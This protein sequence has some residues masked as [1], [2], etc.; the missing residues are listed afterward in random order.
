MFAASL[1]G[2]VSYWDTGE[3]QVVP[4]I[5]GIA[6]PTGFPV[7]TIGAGIFAHVVAIGPV[8][9]RIALFSAIAMS[10]ASWAVFRILREL[11]AE[12]W[13]A[14]GAACVFAFGQIVWTRGT[15]AEVHALAVCLAALTLYFT[16]RWYVRGEPRSFM[17]GALC[18]GLGVATH[19]VVALFAPALLVVV[20]TRIRQLKLRVFAAGLAVLICGLACYAYL[21]VRSAMITQARLDP[22][23]QLGDAP[24]KAFWDMNHPASWDGFKHEVS[25]SEYGSTGFLAAMVN[26]RT[27]HDGAPP[28]LEQLWRE[29]TPFGILLA[30]GGIVALARRDAALAIALLLA[31][32]IPAIFAF[33]Y[34]IEADIA[35]YYL[36]P[37]LVVAI[38]AGYGASA[39][40]RAMP[41]MRTACIVVVAGLA[42][43]LLLIN[44]DTFNQ[45]HS[46]GASGLIGTV[47]AHTPDDAVLLAPWIDSTALAYAA[48]VDRSLGRRIVDSAWLSDEAAR[49][50]GWIRQGRHVYV[51]DQVYGSVP[52]YRLVKIPGSP[53]VYR[54]VKE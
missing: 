4:W 35:R 37:C 8:A 41:E 22:T 52:G 19:P 34:T 33:G 28:F 44:R 40:A 31:G 14:L 6:H 17:A 38:F 3:S 46:S 9:W 25:G 49:V 16:V 11:D 2:A 48:Y 18:W 39:I 20:F 47:V 27:Y 53:D 1:D 24:G 10:V 7:F 12:T 21:P 43:G 45:R 13:I 32:T 30:L 42:I 29:F 15:R 50:P 51:V 23:L 26:P 5:F 54:I 36:I